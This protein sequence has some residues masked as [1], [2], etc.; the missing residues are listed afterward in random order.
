MKHWQA[1]TAAVI[2]M[3]VTAAQ[4]FATFSIVAR[5][6]G[7]GEIGVAVQSKAFNVGMAV[8]WVDAR[9]GAIATQASTNESFGPRGLA[10]MRAG[11]SAEETLAHL[12]ARDE[13]RANRQVGVMDAAGG[14]AQH[15]GASTMA[16]AG[17]VTGDHFAAQGNILVSEEVVAAM[18]RA[19][20][21]TEGDLAYRLLCTLEAAQEAGGDSR[22][23]QSAAILVGRPS[24][25][26][27]EYEARYVDIRVDDHTEPIREIRRLYHMLE[28]SDMALAHIRY[29]EEYRKAGDEAAAQRELDRIGMILTNALA[30]E[31]TTP[32]TLNGLA[33]YLATNDTNL[34]GAL[35]AAERASAAEPESFEILDTLGEVYFRLA[36]YDDAVK[37]GEKALALSPDDEYLK[38]QLD[39]FKN[40]RT[41]LE[42][43]E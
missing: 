29:A 35:E 37:V 8:P 17:G 40:R 38:S 33:W 30:R 18:A 16:W 36:R 21:S 10:L 5:D 3:S 15:T 28:G 19:F 6:P 2:L 43:G 27:P 39:R 11:L 12:L 9:V 7:T 26:H 1:V 22:G 14:I 34:E 25:A 24:A 41:D 20:E 42:P 31:E 4:A 13:G 32:G 23:K